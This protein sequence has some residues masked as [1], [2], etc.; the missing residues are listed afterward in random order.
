MENEKLTQSEVSKLGCKALRDKAVARYYANQ[1]ICKRCKQP[2]PLPEGMR[3]ADAMQKKFCNKSCAAT[4][5]NSEFPKRT[6]KI[7]EYKCTICQKSIA[8]KSYKR[9]HCDE[10][11][12]LQ[13]METK[14][15]KIIFELTRGEIV[16]AKGALYGH[17]YIRAHSRS[18]YKKSKLPYQCFC[19]YD[20]QL[21]NR[22]SFISM[23]DCKLL[24]IQ[25]KHAS[26]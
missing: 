13:R 20:K 4:F 23:R 6:R 5:N 7:N 25:V 3:V 14:F 9:T 21:L 15:G 1:P 10:C 22:L 26:L 8:S 19:G 18:I 24:T 17:N 12:L 2:I 16:A 11:N